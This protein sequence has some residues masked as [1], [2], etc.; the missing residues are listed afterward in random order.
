MIKNIICSILLIT[1]LQS[2]AQ[3]APD[4][5]SV[6]VTNRGG[7]IARFEATYEVGSDIITEPSDHFPG[8]LFYKYINTLTLNK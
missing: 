3:A 4:W 2:L 7:Y 8:I 1:L 6:T 5:T